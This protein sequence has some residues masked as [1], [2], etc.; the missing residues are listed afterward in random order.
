MG[1]FVKWIKDSAPLINRPSLVRMLQENSSFM[2][3]GS[4]AMC[5][6]EGGRSG[7]GDMEGS[8]YDFIFDTN[9]LAV[10]KYLRRKGFEL[11]GQREV[12]PH[13]ADSTFGTLYRHPQVEGLDVLGKLKFEATKSLW[14]EMDPT[15]F[16]IHLW[17]T[18]PYRDPEK[19]EEHKLFIRDYFEEL[20]RV[21]HSILNTERTGGVS[22]GTF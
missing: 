14:K 15:F 9:D 17:K 2:W 20:T 12:D 18:N 10:H 22:D 6:K 5:E 16:F 7:W 21:H 13:Y 1:K 3:V 4:R 8:D 11:V 19:I